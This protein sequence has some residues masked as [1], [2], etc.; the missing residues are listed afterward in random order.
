MSPGDFF[1]ILVVQAI[2]LVLSAMKWWII[3][4]DKKISFNSVLSI[5]LVGYLANGL[6]P[7]SGGEPIRAYLLAKIEN[8][9]LQKA[10]SS[11]FIDFFLAIIPI[12]F[13]TMTV[14][15]IFI[16]FYNFSVFLTYILIMLFILVTSTFLVMIFI[17]QKANIVFIIR[18]INGFSGLL[19]YYMKKSLTS[20]KM[21][22]FLRDFSVTVNDSLSKRSLIIKSLMLS[23]FIRALSLTRTYMIFSMLGF[24]NDPFAIII[25]RVI[26]D[27]ISL[28]SIIPGAIGIWEGTSTLLLTAFGVPA[29]VGFSASLIDRFYSYWISNLIGAFALMRLGAIEIIKDIGSKEAKE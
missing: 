29:T 21:M 27:A 5:S 10:F 22:L 26:V 24:G 16:Y 19:P 2:I 25:V 3:L 4:G 8:I 18:S 28:F 23:F 6:T 14:C 9:S 15:V 1:V 7:I 11:V 12:I 17:V 20:N 13:L